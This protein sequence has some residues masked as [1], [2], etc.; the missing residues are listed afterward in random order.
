MFDQMAVIV[1]IFSNT[2]KSGVQTEKCQVIKQCL[3]V[4]GPQTFPV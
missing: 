1:Q 4:I 2:I 3:I